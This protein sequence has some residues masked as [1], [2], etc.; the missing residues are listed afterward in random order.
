ML[1]NSV[2]LKNYFELNDHLGQINC[3][4]NEKRD[5]NLKRTEISQKIGAVLGMMAKIRE[6]DNSNLRKKVFEQLSLSFTRLQ[7]KF[8]KQEGKCVSTLKRKQKSESTDDNDTRQMAIQAT[9]VAPGKIGFTDVAGLTEVKRLLRE[10]IV[11][12]LKYPHLFSKGRKPWRKILLFGPPGTGKS[13]IARALSSEVA[14]NFYSVSCSDLLSSWFGET[15]KLIKDLFSH[16]KRNVGRSIIF[17]DEIDGLCRRRN[18]NE[19]EQTRRIKTELLK[20]ME[21]SEAQEESNLFVLGATNC[22]WELDTAF[23]RRF[24]KRIYIPLPDKETRRELFSIHLQS[25]PVSITNEEWEEIL[26]SC[27]G[28]SGSDL[29]T[30]VA[31]AVFEPVRELE[32]AKFWKWNSDGKTVSPCAEDE[33][34]AVGINFESIPGDQVT[35]RPVEGR[36]FQ[37]ALRRNHRT[38]NSEELV[39]YEQFSNFGKVDL[40][41]NFP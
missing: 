8:Q 29:S 5:E 14:S 19:Q 11:M 37:N 28:Y 9:I 17:I 18:L 33:D 21:G 41:S 10:A 39:N 40:A 15:E 23:L 13:R 1:G 27:R 31:D 35:P 2:L 16:A 7:G 32:L 34:G 12:P 20:Q 38:V 3:L 4:V 25:V 26:E 24:E 6:C 30:C 22:P 36:D